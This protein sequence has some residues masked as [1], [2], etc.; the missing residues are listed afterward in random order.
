MSKGTKIAVII[1]NCLWLAPFTGG[2]SL[3]VGV[4]GILMVASES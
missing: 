2:V 4:I 1:I 3:A